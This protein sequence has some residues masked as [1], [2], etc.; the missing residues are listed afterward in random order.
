MNAY[1]YSTFLGYRGS[2]LDTGG[3][4]IARI[5][6]HGVCRERTVFDIRWQQTG[7]RA[8]KFLIPHYALAL[9]IQDSTYLHRVTDS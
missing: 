3:W 5:G 6:E 8:Q 9:S 1:T 2:A 4:A 7:V